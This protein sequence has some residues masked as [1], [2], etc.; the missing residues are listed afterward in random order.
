MF[1]L[2]KNYHIVGITYYHLE[3]YLQLNYFTFKLP[4]STKVNKFELSIV[5]GVCIERI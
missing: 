4:M 1:T 2:D 5:K 3:G